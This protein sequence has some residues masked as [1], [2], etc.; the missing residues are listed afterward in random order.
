MHVKK[1]L[2]V[3]AVVGLASSAMA[4]GSFT[5][6]VA[7]NTTH[8]ASGVPVAGPLVRPDASQ[9]TLQAIFGAFNAQGFTNRGM[10]NFI[11]SLTI[12]D[13]AGAATVSLP[14]TSL[15]SPY[16]F[17][18]SISVVG[19]GTGINFDANRGSGQVNVPWGVGE[20]RPDTT[21][22][23]AAN[24]GGPDAYFPGMRFFLNPGTN[25]ARDITI[26][27]TGPM[28]AISSWFFLGGEEGDSADLLPGSFVQGTAT[29]TFVVSIVPA[30][31]AAALLGLGGLMAARRRR[32]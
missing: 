2:A 28:Q 10:F 25:A 26:T 11:G 15:R 30:P 8:L 7:F 18:S 22:A 4:Q 5:G 3:L 17:G 16:N 9:V 32:A 23:Y 27:V 31:G 19:G 21:F 6:Q 29:G 1:V 13:P 20:P 12:S 14:A 24:N